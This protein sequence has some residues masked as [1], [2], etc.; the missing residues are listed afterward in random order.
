MLS[1]R[2]HPRSRP[3]LSALSGSLRLATS[4]VPGEVEFSSACAARTG[5]V[6]AGLALRFAGRALA[7]ATTLARYGRG[8]ALSGAGRGRHGRG[9]RTV[10]VQPP[11]AYNPGSVG[12]GQ[13]RGEVAGWRDA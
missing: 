5:S 9:R 4:P 1:A 2:P 13:R 10:A 6:G 12:M 3:R 11:R 8:T 7:G